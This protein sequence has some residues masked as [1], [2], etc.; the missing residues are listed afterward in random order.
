MEKSSDHPILAGN[1]KTKSL[2]LFLLASFSI[3]M[4][5]SIFPLNI[6]GSL[7]LA[8]V[9]TTPTPVSVSNAWKIPFTSRFESI[10][11]SFFSSSLPV[12]P[13][14]KCTSINIS[15]FNFHIM[16][17]HFSYYLWR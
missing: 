11:A 10:D 13:H 15:F 4:G 2:C 9:K 3:N 6:A 17:S 12:L 8:P 14:E 1:P 16:I 7:G 5:C